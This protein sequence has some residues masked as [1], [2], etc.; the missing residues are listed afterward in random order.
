MPNVSTWLNREEGKAFKKRVETY[1]L[2]EYAL[3]KELVLIELGKSPRK[4]T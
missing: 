2:T 3:L 4:R 1:G